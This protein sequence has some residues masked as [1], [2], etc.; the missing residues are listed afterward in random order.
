MAGVA[1][2]SLAWQLAA[3]LFEMGVCEVAASR[4]EADCRALTPSTLCRGRSSREEGPQVWS[5]ER[6]VS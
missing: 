5:P 1:W 6:S 2:L 4:S 3:R